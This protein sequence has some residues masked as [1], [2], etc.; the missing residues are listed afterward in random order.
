MRRMIEQIVFVL[1]VALVA[2]TAQATITFDAIVPSPPTANELVSIQMSDG[3]C[4]A[5]IEASGYPLITQSGNAIRV[6][7]ETLHYD[8]QALCIFEPAT[9]LTGI[10]TFPPGSYAL[11]IDRHYT[12]FFSNPVIET[13]GTATLSV[14]GGEPQTTA[15]PMLEGWSVM[16]L[17]LG[18]SL[19][20]V[21]S[22]KKYRHTKLLTV[23]LFLVSVPLAPRA[24]AAPESGCRSLVESITAKAVSYKNQERCVIETRDCAATIAE[25]RRAS[26]SIVR[27]GLPM[28]GATIQSIGQ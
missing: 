4:D 17:I 12:D 27:A 1:A 7:L 23:L 21:M 5:L 18:V 22:S 13:V 25:K 10:G 15:L 20:G 6:V 3:G 16:L 26:A 24:H 11:Q 9:G 8:D 2:S 14:S 19:F 28:Q